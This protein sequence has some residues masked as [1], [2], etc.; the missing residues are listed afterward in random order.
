MQP[1]S[2]LGTATHH[3]RP[4]RKS[5]WPARLDWLQ[6]V[7]GLLLALFIW[8]H[9]L[10]ESSILLG[11][12]AMW[13]VS[14]FFEGYYI[15]GRPLPWIVSIIAAV[16]FAL[17]MLHAVLAL[18]KFPI[19]YRQYRSFSD[20]K[21]SMK[22]ADTTQWWWQVITGFAMFFLAPVHLYVVMSRPDRIGPYA[23]ADRVWSDY[24]WP[25][26]LV[27]L[28]VVVVHAIVGLYRLALKWGWF[29][30]TG[31]DPNAARR[32]LN[33]LKW[34]LTAFFL[35]LGLVTLAA[36]VRIGIE[37]AAHA[38]ERYTPAWAVQPPAPP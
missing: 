3:D 23:S 18:R 1:A 4:G 13:R 34:A 29:A 9:L 36:Y 30:G 35:V 6:S 7:S 25:L 38:G 22:H 21:H 11:K 10:F 28:I 5:R 16:V 37:H 26:Y 14:K 20:H 24:F 17:L 32:R 31:T 15:F 19:N 27:L 12:D 2:A 8:G 33:T